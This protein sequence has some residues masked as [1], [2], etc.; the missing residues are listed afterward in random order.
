MSLLLKEPCFHSCWFDT[1]AGY[2][3]KQTAIFI[4]LTK[5]AFLILPKKK[6][7]TI[8]SDISN[9]FVECHVLPKPCVIV[10]CIKSYFSFRN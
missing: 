5:I 3:D 8:K 9:L 10:L 4:M 6:E 1:N 7:F 2:A